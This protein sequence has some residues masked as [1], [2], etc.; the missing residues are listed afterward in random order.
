LRRKGRYK[1][2]QAKVLCAHPKISE[3]KKA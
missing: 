1:A 2:R 3:W